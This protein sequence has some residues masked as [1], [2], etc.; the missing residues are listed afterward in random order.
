ML[1]DRKVVMSGMVP[2]CPATAR[3]GG[4]SCMRKLTPVITR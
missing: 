1:A 2:G 4:A 3:S